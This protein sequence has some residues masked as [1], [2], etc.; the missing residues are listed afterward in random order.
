MKLLVTTG[1]GNIIQGGA[2]I[3]VNHF[4]DNV[5]PILKGEYTIF[6]DGKRPV[7]F[8]TS[9]TNFH[10]HGDDFKRSEELLEKCEVIH[11]LHA[12][13]HKR[14]HLWKHKDK[15]GTIIVHAYLP[16]MLKYG[17]SPKQFNTKIDEDSV[18]E[19]LSNCKTRVW[20]GNNKSQIFHK[21][22][23]E[24][25]PN[26]YEFKK[27]KLPDLKSHKLGYT[28]RIESRKNIHYLDEHFGYVLSNRYDWKNISEKGDYDFSKIKFYQWDSEIHDLFMN[29]DWDISHSCHINEP[30]GYSIFQSI[31]YGKIPIIHSEWGVE[32]DYKYRASSKAEFNFRYSQIL[33][34]SRMI[35]LREFLKLKSYMRKFENKKKWVEKI[36]VFFK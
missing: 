3:W 30:F 7:G 11:F 27:N 21:F 18:D 9:L 5:L 31:D 15:W 12:N 36:Y 25:V 34:D 35:H 2:D 22:E 13:Y 17:D 29:K 16:D 32:C 20:I 23:V 26:F 10:F 4:I 14:D 1:F 6:V 8:E 28:S 24:K 19:L 33:R